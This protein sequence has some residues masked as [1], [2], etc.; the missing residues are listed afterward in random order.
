MTFHSKAYLASPTQAHCHLVPFPKTNGVLSPPHFSSFPWG[1]QGLFRTKLRQVG[2][3][4]EKALPGPYHP[5]ELYAAGHEVK[6]VL[7]VSNMAAHHNKDPRPE[8]KKSVTL[9][10]VG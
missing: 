4:K 10:F 2:I 8:G 5:A 7:S 1:F 9:G 6:I 3:S